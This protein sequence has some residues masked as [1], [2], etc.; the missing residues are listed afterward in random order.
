MAEK[1]WVRA[2]APGLALALTA[3]AFLAAQAVQ[4]PS[5][6]TN[7]ELVQSDVVVFDRQGR[8]VDNIPREQFEV[9]VDGQPRPIAAFERIQAGSRIERAQLAATR[10]VPEP[11]AADSTSAEGSRT[12]LF[13]VDDFHMAQ[14]GLARTHQI[15]NNYIETKMGPR[16]LVAI[17]SPSGQLGFLQQLTSS[18]TMLHAAV[19][20]LSNRTRLMIDLDQP[21]MSIHQAQVIEAVRDRELFTFFVR[22]TLRRNPLIK[23]PEAENIV[24][25]RAR[26]MVMQ[27][28]SI[29]RTTVLTLDAL[30]RSNGQLPGRKLVV[31]ISDGL[32]IDPTWVEVSDAV[33]Q[34]TEASAQNNFVIYTMDSRGLVT[35]SGYS[36]ASDSA[37]ITTRQPSFNPYDGAISDATAAIDRANADE[38]FVSQGPL[39]Q[40]AYETGGRM[41]ANSNA[42][43]TFLPRALEETSIYYLLAWIPPSAAT[44]TERKANRAHKVDIRVAG[45]PELSVRFRRMYYDPA[46]LQEARAATDR[47]PA[48][49]PDRRTAP[50]SE[51]KQIE[52]VLLTAL[53]AI[54]PVASLPTGVALAFMDIPNSGSVVTASMQ[55]DAKALGFTGASGETALVDVA[56]A[57]FD[58]EG[59]GVSSFKD[60]VTL[61]T[62]RNDRLTYV[63]KFQLKPGLYQIRVAA[64]DAKTGAVGSASEWIDIPKMQGGAFS[65]S[66]LILQ[67]G[68]DLDLGSEHHLA[69]GEALRFV[70]YVYNASKG[71]AAPD[72][73]VRIEVIRGEKT[74][75][76]TRPSRLRTENATD[77]ARIPY[78]AELNLEGMASGSYVLH[79]TATD[80]TSQTTT[81]QRMT[82]NIE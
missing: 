73:T 55:L 15:L 77:L 38:L 33:R 45:R 18:K 65:L 29:A 49:A 3:P 34:I 27:A 82:F 11:S 81:S 47:Q 63:R 35:Q 42:F 6:R 43:D 30:V 17:A 1:G 62:P 71:K 9:L 24:M 50:V 20:R 48:A 67:R 57:V 70:T 75:I 12:V 19:S 16:D 53:R 28:A 31:F 52:E 22:E 51:E 2:C 23:P 61:S 60:R 39:Y 76:A 46:P 80:R 13:F 44:A 69:R 7:T 66:S 56:N 78:V 21:V 8:F 58:D 79:V 5:F 36:A 41:F 40:L 10:G 74:V 26:Q 14:G 72:V 68:D 32:E 37:Q 64:R 54:P 4:N 59:K 25:G